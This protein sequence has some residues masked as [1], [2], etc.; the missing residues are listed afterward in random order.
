MLHIIGYNDK[1]NI[2]ISVM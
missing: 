1:F 2:M